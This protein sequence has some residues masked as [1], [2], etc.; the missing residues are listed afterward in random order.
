MA[1]RNELHVK[2][3]TILSPLNEQVPRPYTVPRGSFYVDAERDY[4]DGEPPERIRL[5]F[6][7]DGVKTDGASTFWPI[8]LL[9][10]QWR[11]GDD[12]Y[13]AAPLAHDLLYVKKGKVTC[14]GPDD[15]NCHTARTIQLTREECDDVLRGMWRVWGMGRGLAGAADLAIQAFAGGESHWGNDD[16]GI[17]DRFSIFLE[18][19]K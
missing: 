16:Y 3:V 8:S 9:V 6:V 13:N 15:G 4:H 11:P 17:A 10:P 1:K 2:A 7:Y 12:K 19:L 14:L 18:V 5:T